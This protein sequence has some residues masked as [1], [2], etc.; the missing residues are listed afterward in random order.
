[1]TRNI[2]PWTILVVLTVSTSYAHAQH[3]NQHHSLCHSSRASSMSA[4]YGYGPRVSYEESVL[5]G[6]AYY[7]QAQAQANLVNAQ[8]QKIW[9]ENDLKA[10]ENRYS[11]GVAIAQGRTN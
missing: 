7:A 8:A 9:L 5:R 2:V 1:M 10:V 11:K 3:C 4:T 6:M